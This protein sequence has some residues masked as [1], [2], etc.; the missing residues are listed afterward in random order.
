MKRPDGK[1]LRHTDP[2]YRVGVHLMPKR[3]D[4]M[5][6]ITLD[7]PYEPIRQYVRE[8][9]KQGIPMSNMTVIL[10][11]LVRLTAEYPPINRFVMNKRVYTREQIT[12]G[13]V[14]MG[15]KKGEGTANEGTMSKIVFEPTDNIFQINEKIEKYIAENRVGDNS[16]E[17]I[18]HTITSIPGV[19]RGAANLIR[20]TDKHN[21]LPKAIIDASPFHCSML[22]TNLASIRTNHIYHHIY[23]FGTTSMSFA[24][25][26]PRQVPK[27][28]NGEIV[29]EHCIPLGMV[30]DDR[31]V[32][33]HYFATAFH[34][35]KQLYAD[36]SLMEV[37]LPAPIP[38]PEL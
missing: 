18:I 6:A 17:K 7:I 11:G 31:T 38:D 4:A 34:R 28:K 3:S 23:D 25:G 1:L 16:A 27:Q 35:L 36:P 14:V 8:K 9:K 5:N 12:V 33:G 13:M 24:M 21:L 15:S 29:F 2:M 22:F 30:M 26:N 20:W 37:G 10:A 32:S 19:L